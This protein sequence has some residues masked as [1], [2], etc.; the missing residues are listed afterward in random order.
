MKKYCLT[1]YNSKESTFINP[2]SIF[3]PGMNSFIK[4]TTLIIHRYMT[5]NHCTIGEMTIVAITRIP[6]I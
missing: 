5:I 1:S 3:N 2:I 6:V 4:I